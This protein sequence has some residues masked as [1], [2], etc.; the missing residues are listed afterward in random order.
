MRAIHESGTQSARR[1][2]SLRSRDVNHDVGCV[3]VDPIWHQALSVAQ[4]RKGG[5]ASIM[6]ERKI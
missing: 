6:I 1:F 4:G 5:L 3:W 2:W